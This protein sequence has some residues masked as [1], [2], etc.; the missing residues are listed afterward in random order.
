VDR[1][2]NRGTNQVVYFDN[3]K[4]TAT[5]LAD[6]IM[7]PPPVDPPTV[8]APTP[9]AR[10]PSDVISIFSDAYTNLPGT[11]IGKNWGEATTASN[12]VI[13]SDSIKKL[14]TF[15][16]QGIVLANPVNMTGFE[17]VH[18]D[19]FKTDQEQ[20]KF[21]IINVGGGDV[22]K[23]LTISNPGW[24]SFD[25]PL[26]EFI[27]LNLATVHQMKLEGAPTQGNTTVYFDNLYV[28]RGLTSVADLS[29]SGLEIFPNPA[30]GK[31]VVKGIGEIS[32]ISLFDC[33]GRKV[34]T[35]V[36][37]SPKATINTATLDPGVYVVKA[38][39]GK[40]IIVSRF[41]KN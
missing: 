29:T 13:G 21:S 3:L 31:V 11:K 26:S 36:P 40:K 37:N 14:V 30:S 28:Y 41:V 12:I 17:K 10:Q 2:A 5:K 20:L 39:I 32:E 25:I 8:S 19:F 38:T 34:L 23:L 33:L 1:N 6:P 15:N 9:P 35:D 7:P 16:Y 4:F 24:N 27:G 18:I 22:T